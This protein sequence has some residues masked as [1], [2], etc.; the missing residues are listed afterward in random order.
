MLLD[1]LGTD[2]F[3]PPGLQVLWPF[4][5]HFFYSG[6]DLFPPVERRILR[7]E[8]FAVNARA[9]FWELIIIGPVTAAAWFIKGGRRK[10]AALSRST[11]EARSR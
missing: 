9:A 10:I 11:H 4:N 7:P 2:R 5:D 6:V 3:P 1:W 8:A